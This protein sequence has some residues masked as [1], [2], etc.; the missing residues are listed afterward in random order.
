MQ[1]PQAA[2]VFCLRDFYCGQNLDFYDRIVYNIIVF[3][4]ILIALTKTGNIPP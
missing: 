1:H 2:S 3:L 4:Y